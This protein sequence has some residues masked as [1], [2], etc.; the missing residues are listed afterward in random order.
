MQY[1]LLR[2]PERLGEDGVFAL[3]HDPLPQV[4]PGEVRIRMS[5]VSVDP[6]MRGW[7]TPKRSYM[8]P[9]RPGE[10][11]RAFGVGEVLESSADGVAVGDWMTGFTGV[12]SEAVL[13]ARA[14][15]K[16]DT[17]LAPARDFLG[18]LGMTGYTA[19]FGLLDVGKPVA[20]ET[21]VVS[22]AAGAVGSIA[23]QIARIKGC[24]VIGIAGGPAKCQYLTETI[25][26]DVAI[27]YKNQ[28]VAAEVAKAAPGGINVFFDNV[29]GEILDIALDNLAPA[30][31]R[32]SICGAISQYADLNDVRGPKLYL[33]LAERNAM[34][35]GF[36]V[37]HYAAQHPAAMDCALLLRD[38]MLRLPGEAPVP[39]NISFRVEIEPRLGRVLGR[40][41]YGVV[42]EAEWR[43][44]KARYRPIRTST[45]G[46]TA[47]MLG[48]HG[49][50]PSQRAA[51]TRWAA[52]YSSVAICLRISATP[53][54]TGL[55][56]LSGVADSAPRYASMVRSGPTRR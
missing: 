22:A 15:R 48:R 28:D 49:S 47:S 19:Y 38:G 56:P 4:Q 26:A 17:R 53:R 50:A 32:V 12:Q 3:T 33:R 55:M 40:G 54:I 10:V 45:H 9:V 20:G 37:S 51:N 24:R 52:D 29:G 35:K 46:S 1:R 23:A 18:G 25:G 34:M 5:H 41:G 39:L 43:G 14:L 30:G 16:I 8:P 2:Y 42:Y 21:V 6:G 36:V 11:M 7:M 31:A 44:R 13:P 27:D